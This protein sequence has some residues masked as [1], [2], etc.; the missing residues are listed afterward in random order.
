M[1]QVDDLS[2][3]LAA[4]DQNSTLTMVVEM[5]AA[6]WLVAGM[7][8]GIDRLPVKK[9]ESDPDGLL[10]LVDYWLRVFGQVAFG[11]KALESLTL[12]RI[13]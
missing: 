7:I 4:F 9:L 6:S 11:R 2:R 3:S 1:T 8:P 12:R 13:A 5:S 10:R